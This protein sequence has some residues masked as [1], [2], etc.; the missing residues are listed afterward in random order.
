MRIGRNII[1]PKLVNINLSRNKSFEYQLELSPQGFDAF[2]LSFRHTVRQDHAGPSF[3]FGLNGLFWLSL[4]V[5]D[6]RHWDY[7]KD[8]YVDDEA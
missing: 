3:T 2:E 7:L 4:R 5:Y 8:R 6:H 1:G